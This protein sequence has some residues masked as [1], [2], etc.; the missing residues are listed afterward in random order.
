[1]KSKQSNV[2]IRTQDLGRVV[3]D[4]NVEHYDNMA[5]DY[6]ELMSEAYTSNP[7]SVHRINEVLESIASTSEC[8]VL[9]DVGAGTGNFMLMA[10]NRFKGCYGV[11][12]SLNMAKIANG[13]GLSVCVADVDA[14]PF[15]NDF[16]N[17]ICGYNL[18]H[19]LYGQEQFFKEAHRVLKTGGTLYTD[20]DP[21]RASRRV[22]KKFHFFNLMSVIFHLLFLPGKQKQKYHKNETEQ[23]AEYH[24]YQTSG[25]DCGEIR[26]LLK[27]VGFKDV[28]VIAHG[29]SQ[30]FQNNTFFNCPWHAKIYMLA[31]SLLSLRT[32]YNDIAPYF[33]V[34]AKK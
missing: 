7:S 18:L 9:V 15:P 28:N 14:L 23:F 11:D 20:N 22:L 24:H 5:Q 8:E 3:R 32:S 2:P 25:L 4:A 10:K 30:S 34:L 29:D 31:V 19:H 27:K 13:K 1:M 17:A 6:D 21:N 12:I 16:A 26:D 33:M